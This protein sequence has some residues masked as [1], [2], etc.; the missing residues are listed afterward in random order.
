MVRESL[1]PISEN[2]T[3]WQVKLESSPGVFADTLSATKQYSARLICI[4]NLKVRETCTR[5]NPKDIS[6]QCKDDGLSCE[7]SDTQ[8]QKLPN[9]C[10]RGDDSACCQLAA[11]QTSISVRFCSI[12]HTSIMDRRLSIL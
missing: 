8:T 12:F 2:N 4:H 10:P 5:Y 3:A 7:L 1:F 6:S 11:I 9:T